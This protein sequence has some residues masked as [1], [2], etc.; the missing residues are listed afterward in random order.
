MNYLG[1]DWTGSVELNSDLEEFKAIVM[2]ADGN[3]EGLN[4]QLSLSIHVNCR[5]SMDLYVYSPYWIMNKTGL[6][7]QMRVSW[8]TFKVIM[9]VYFLY[10]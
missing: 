7:I 9:G 1:M 6:P 4:R 10:H 2:E 3:V 8:T 5:R